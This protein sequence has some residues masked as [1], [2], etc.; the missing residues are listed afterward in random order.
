MSEPEYSVLIEMINKL[1]DKVD[2]LVEGFQQFQ[3]DVHDR[4]AGHDKRI[5][6]VEKYCIDADNSHKRFWDYVLR[7]IP[8]VLM[9]ITL[10]ITLLRK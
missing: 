3:I 8:I 4:L 10:T 2:D 1:G 9:V 7:A 5:A 6:F